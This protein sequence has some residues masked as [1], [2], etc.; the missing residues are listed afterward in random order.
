MRH[1]HSPLP[2]MHLGD[3]VLAGRLHGKGAHP[4][5]RE[6]HRQRGWKPW[7]LEGHVAGGPLAWLSLCGFFPARTTRREENP[8]RVWGRNGALPF[9]G[10]LS[11]G[12]APMKHRERA[13]HLPE[14]AGPGGPRRAPPTWTWP[15]PAGRSCGGGSSGSCAITERTPRS[16]SCRS[17]STWPRPR[18]RSPS[19]GRPPHRAPRPGAWSSFG[20]R[21]RESTRPAARAHGRRALCGVQPRRP[22]AGLGGKRPDGSPAP[23]GRRMLAELPDAQ[24]RQ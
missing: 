19:W 1:D 6:T 18:S 9:G 11:G 21:P 20:T 5:Q 16:C 15:A 14:R 23:P 7:L 12:W 13:R 10:G 2:A 24:R 17:W 3:L 22:M 4:V 8:W